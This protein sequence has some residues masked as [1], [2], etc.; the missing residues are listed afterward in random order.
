MRRAWLRAVYFLK[1]T[2]CLAVLCPTPAGAL[3]CPL[4]A[5]GTDAT[6]RG[7]IERWASELTR[8]ADGPDLAQVGQRVATEFESAPDRGDAALA[9]LALSRALCEALRADSQLPEAQK[10]RRLLAA[11]EAVRLPEREGPAPSLDGDDAIA[12]VRVVLRSAGGRS[13]GARVDAEILLD[14]ESRALSPAGAAPG[15]IGDLLTLVVAPSTPIPARA[16]RDLELDLRRG[17]SGSFRFFL[18]GV[19]LRSQGGARLAHAFS[20]QGPLELGPQ[21][22]SYALVLR[23][24]VC[25]SERSGAETR[26][27]DS[28]AF[29]HRAGTPRY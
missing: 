28:P 21:R 24:E 4:F 17:G 18:E 16:C 20:P 22:N 19:E 27:Q 2:A 5:D 7:Q 13:E 3:E 8:A 6:E 26:A 29:A 11:L 25:P 9:R 1:G 14:G 10:R 12:E 23:T 15:E